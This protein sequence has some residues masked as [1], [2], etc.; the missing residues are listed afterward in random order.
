MVKKDEYA[1]ECDLSRLSIKEYGVVDPIPFF[2]PT[3]IECDQCEERCYEDIGYKVDNGILRAFI[4]CN[5]G[6]RVK[7]TREQIEKEMNI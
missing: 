4:G 7:I 1:L 2:W 3:S 6:G 5:K